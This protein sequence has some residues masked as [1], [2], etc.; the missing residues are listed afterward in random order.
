MSLEYPRYASVKRLAFHEGSHS[1]FLANYRRLLQAQGGRD[2][3]PSN[4]AQQLF[5]L[6][7]DERNL[8][9]ALDQVV[10]TARSDSAAAACRQWT[11]AEKWSYARQLREVLRGGDYRPPA[12]TRRSIPKQSG[13]GR[14]TI[15]VFE[16]RER[17]ISRGV[18][19]IVEPILARQRDPLSFC[20]SGGGA[21]RALAQLDRELAVRDANVVI[22]EDMANAF[23]NV[24]HKPLRELLQKALPNDDVCQLVS[25]LA[26]RRDIEQGVYQGSKLSLALLDFY[27]SRTLHSWWSRRDPD[28]PLIRYV[29]DVIVPVGP[30]QRPQELYERVAQG[31][32]TAGFKPKL[33]SDAA[34]CDL[35]RG[36]TTWL[37]YRLS[38]NDS[39]LQVGVAGKLAD[40]VEARRLLTAGYAEL[41]EHAEPWL[42]AMAV[43]DGLLAH[44]APAYPHV[45]RGAVLQRIAAASR[46]GGC[47]EPRIQGDLIEQ[48]ERHYGKWRAMRDAIV[49]EPLPSAAPQSPRAATRP[50]RRRRVSGCQ[51]FISRCVRIKPRRSSGA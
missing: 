38:R 51:T 6:I 10:R 34:I 47:D 16:L 18:L 12:P 37:G 15:W 29:D 32:Q 24:P 45:D 27:L 50:R 7:A 11:E 20:R 23:D 1:E 19:Q 49:I 39:G 4:I 43:T 8:R 22:C 25:D 14:R 17:V 46:A 3:L 5:G 30:E 26:Y 13:N 42:R 35:R 31:F 36:Q 44:A 9:L 48:W 41:H 28:A 33:G 40:D 21:A 2:S